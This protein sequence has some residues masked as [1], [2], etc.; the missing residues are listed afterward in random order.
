MALHDHNQGFEKR[1]GKKESGKAY[2]AFLTY[3]ELGRQRSVKKTAEVMGVNE[4]ALKD[5]CKKYNWVERAAS[6]D[7]DKVK[8]RFADVRKEREEQ[9]RAA[10]R[11]FR[12]ET[13][14]RAHDMGELADLMMEITI[15]KIQ[16]MRAQGELPSEQQL[17]NLAKT[18]GSLSE[19]TMNLKATALGIDELVDAVDSELGE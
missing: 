2:E 17:S 14:R 19:M 10:I 12:E 16:D 13:E 11:K 1:A 9:H 6:F 5:F 18:V 3:C 8:A 4:L 15:E 7:A